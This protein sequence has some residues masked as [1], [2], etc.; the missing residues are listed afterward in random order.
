MKLLV[1]ICS[2][3]MDPEYSENIAI[4]HNYLM[5]TPDLNVEYCGISGRDD[6]SNYESHINFKYKVITQK[7][8]F[9]KICDFISD[10]RT[11]LDY[12]WYMKIRPDVKLLEPIDFTALSDLAINARARQYRGPKKLMYAMSINGE[13]IWNNIGDCFY[14]QE[15][16]H[17]ILDD[18]IFIFHN[19][20]INMGAFDKM[21]IYEREVEWTQ[22]K[23][24]NMRNIRLNVCRIKLVNTKY[25]V[26]SGHLNM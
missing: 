15:E 8:Q 21:D 23:I 24:W 5:Q 11:H 7:Q 26:Q 18:M 9:T 25:N 13:G 1:M 17:I 20:V 3:E 19:N 12:D 22:T 16:R 2:H 14:D 4:L 6:F 10:N